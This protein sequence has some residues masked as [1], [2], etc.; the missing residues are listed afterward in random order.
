MKTKTALLAALVFG[1]IGLG[2]AGSPAAAAPVG[3]VLDITAGNGH[4]GITKISTRRHVRRHRMVRRH[5]ARHNRRIHRAHRNYN[6]G[7][8][9]IVAAKESACG[10]YYRKAMTTGY[11]YWWVKYNHSCM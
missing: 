1:G 3:F 10:F 4:S 6:F 2:M 11:R 5:R 9:G 7:Y 8:T